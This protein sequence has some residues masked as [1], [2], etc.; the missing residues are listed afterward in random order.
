[1]EGSAKESAEENIEVQRGAFLS[2]VIEIVFEAQAFIGSREDGGEIGLRPAHDSGLDGEAVDV[3]GNE[4]GE[5][6]GEFGSDRGRAEESHFAA[7]DVKQLRQAGEAKPGNEIAR[8]D[9][10][11]VPEAGAEAHAAKRDALKTEAFDALK[12]RRGGGENDQHGDQDEQRGGKK[13][14]TQA[15]QVGVNGLQ[16]NGGAIDI[17]T[18]SEE[19]VECPEAIPADSL[20]DIFEK[21]GRILNGHACIAEGQEA[22][23]RNVRGPVRLVDD[24]GCGLVRSDRGVERAQAAEQGDC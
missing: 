4:P 7:D 9:R 13:K 17:E 15:D 23:R 24:D 5:V 14:K 16:G 6:F 12:G 1:M 10:F 20:E 18:R 2:Y 21:S 8:P 19:E 11:S 22:A 3:S